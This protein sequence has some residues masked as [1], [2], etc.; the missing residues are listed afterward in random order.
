VPLSDPAFIPRGN[1]GEEA[2]VTIDLVELHNNIEQI[3][4]TS[5]AI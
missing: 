1:L 4:N 2:L 5:G 3:Y